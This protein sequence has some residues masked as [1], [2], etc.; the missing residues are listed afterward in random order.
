MLSKRNCAFRVAGER[1][2]VEIRPHICISLYN[3]EIKK[4]IKPRPIE[5]K[6]FLFIFN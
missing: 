5:S 2:A 1:L 6:K 3:H 4:L